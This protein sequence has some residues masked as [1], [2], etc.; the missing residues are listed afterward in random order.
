M[1]GTG[2]VNSKFES[3]KLAAEDEVQRAARKEEEQMASEQYLTVAW[4]NLI[5]AVTA[6][7]AEW[8]LL[9]SAKH[10]QLRTTPGRSGIHYDGQ[11]GFILDL[12]LD[13][14]T[15]S[16]KYLAPSQQ[17][18]KWRQHN[19]ELE[20]TTDAEFLGPS[21]ERLSPEQASRFLLEPVLFA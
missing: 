8:N 17:A 14:R 7:I 15:A 2:W 1:A 21:R 6:D 20:I 4:Q 5:V 13:R 3:N 16:V 19:G 12:Q 9:R 10:V 18:S 11:L